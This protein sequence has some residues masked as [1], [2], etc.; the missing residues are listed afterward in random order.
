MGA[1][2]SALSGADQSAQPSEGVPDTKDQDNQEDASGPDQVVLQASQEDQDNKEDDFESEV[3]ESFDDMKLKDELLKG[4]YEFG[5]EKPSNIQ[6]RGIVPCIKG[7]DTIVKA[8]SGTGKTATFCISALQRVKTEEPKC[9]VLILV[10]T[11]E[12]ARQTLKVLNDLG[13][14]MKIQSHA[15]VGG[16]A[17]SEDIQILQRGVQIVV[18]TPD[19]VFDMINR[20]ALNPDIVLMFV[21][22]EADTM[23]SNGFELKIYDIFKRL[24][25]NLQVCLF[26]ATLPEDVV[27]MAQ[28]FMHNPLRIQ[29]EEEKEALTLTGLRHFHCV[30]EQEE[31]KFDTISD[32][33]ETLQMAHTVVYCNTREKIEWLQDKMTSRGFSV[34]CIHGE[35]DMVKRQE[36]IKEFRLG[37]SRILITTELMERG[38]ERMVINYDLPNQE[39]Y[40]LRVGVK[41]S[42]GRSGSALTFISQDDIRSLK[43]IEDAYN[44]EILEMPMDPTEMV[45]GVSVA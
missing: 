13:S 25:S 38:T 18:G 14:H 21:L 41:E 1:G 23:L 19:C 28:R 12:V 35:M 10:P 16:T 39:N 20:D 9:Q 15:C 6:Q 22:D 32:L 43:A 8:Q 37:S 11:T 26:S 44:I 33:Y 34:S 30:I 29:E 24:P 45:V 3:C 7:N 40:L 17:L 36:I 42:I 31:W 27:N 4:I 2:D 5:L